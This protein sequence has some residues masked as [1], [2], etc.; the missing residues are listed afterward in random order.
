[1]VTHSTEGRSGLHATVVTEE[2]P[3]DPNPTL[4][5]WKELSS[6]RK[7]CVLLRTGAAFVRRPLPW[8]PWQQS[9]SIQ[10]HFSEM[11]YWIV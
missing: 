6:R 1:M 8:Q 3:L 7:T 9:N 4:P 2:D 5:Q 10:E 11:L